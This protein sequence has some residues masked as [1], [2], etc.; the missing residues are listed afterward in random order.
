M[1]KR[2]GIDFLRLLHHSIVNAYLL[3][4][5]EEF[6]YYLFLLF[7]IERRYHLVHDTGKLRLEGSDCLADG[8]DV[9]YEDSGIPIV[10][11]SGNVLLGCLQ[12][13]IFLESLYLV[14]FIY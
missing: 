12:V 10:I 1:Y 9:S 11:A 7:G 6:A 13:W 4:G 3:A 2:Q 5:W 8:I 14:D